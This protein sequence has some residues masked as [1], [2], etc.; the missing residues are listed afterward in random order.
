LNKLERETRNKQK[1]LSLELQQELIKLREEIQQID[2]MIKQIK[3]LL[4]NKDRKKS[5]SLLKDIIENYGNK[6]PEVIELLTKN[7]EGLLKHQKDKK[8]PKTN[9]DAENTNR[10][11]KR[12]LKTIEAFQRQE[13]AENYLIIICNYLRM[14]PYT[15]CRGVRRYRNGYSP[16]QLCRA[17]V[18][19]NDWVK[20]SLNYT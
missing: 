11:I 12:R 13:N 15:D 6:Y 18:S 14:K 7:K 4:W 16:L 17:K 1:K 5:E 2:N 20:F 10:Q 19:S 3:Q 9:N 8:I